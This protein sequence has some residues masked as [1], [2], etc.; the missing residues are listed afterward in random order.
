MNVYTVRP[1]ALDSEQEKELLHL[2]NVPKYKVVKVFSW[3]I[4]WKYLY[5]G[6]LKLNIDGA[7]KGNPGESGGWTILRNSRGQLVL[8]GSYL[9]GICMNMEAKIKALRSD[10]HLL[11]EYGLQDYEIIIETYSKLQ[12]DMVNQR[13]K[14]SWKLW[15]LLGKIFS[16]L[17]HFNF[18]LQ[19]TYR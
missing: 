10:L 17:R 3:W 1:K 14:A 18:H 2:L 12:V 11:R 8:V 13:S 4:A 7:S 9:Y 5:M 6:L 19:Q 16:T 15:S